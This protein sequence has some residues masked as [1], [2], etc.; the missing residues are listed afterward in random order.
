M[1][2][3]QQLKQDVANELGWE[4]S[5]NEAHIGVSVKHGIVTLTGHV[6]SYGEKHGAEK[7]AKRVYGVKAVANELD[8]RLPSSSVRTNEDIAVACVEALAGHPAVP[9][10]KIKVIVENDGW[11]TLEG[12][13]EWQAHKEA[14]EDAVRYLP[15]VRGV[16]NEIT[17]APGVSPLDVKERIQAAFKRNA[18]LDARRITVETRDGRVILNGEVRSWAEKGVAQQAAWSAPGVIAVENNLVV[19]E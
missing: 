3:D 2:T 11:V 6:P 19:T 1:R 15:G 8:V 16:T 10:D 7:A 12:G 13:V 17:L 4:P 14:A 9:K 5:V 18:E